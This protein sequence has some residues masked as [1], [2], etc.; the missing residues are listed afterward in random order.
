MFIYHKTTDRT[1]K[2]KSCNRG[3][4]TNSMQ[5]T[6]KTLSGR[7]QTFNFDQE[8]KVL[9]V[10]QALQEKE[11]KQGAPKDHNLPRI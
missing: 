7:K 9:V 11:G 8:N 10:K 3:C 5:I 6:I 4:N 1:R 2:D